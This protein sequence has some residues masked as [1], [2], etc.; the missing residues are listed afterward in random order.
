MKYHLIVFGC[1]MNEADGQR[2]SAVFEKQN[3]KKTSK[4]NEADLVC[5]VMCSVR[6]SAVDRVFG[7]VEKI[8]GLNKKPTTILTGCILKK[9]KK[10][11]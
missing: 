2:L 1:Q 9:D 6:Q 8:K 11:F 3:Y 7:L 4:L 5:V 10:T